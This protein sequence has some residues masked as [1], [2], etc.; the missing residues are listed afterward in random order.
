MSY[1]PARIPTDAPIRT[2][3][4]RVLAELARRRGVE[5]PCDLETPEGIYHATASA[6]VSRV[7]PSGLAD[8]ARAL[9]WKRGEAERSADPEFDRLTKELYQLYCFLVGGCGE[10]SAELHQEALTIAAE[11]ERREIAAALAEAPAEAPAQR[12]SGRL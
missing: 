12:R 1:L 8:S 7:P 9:E 2:T 5:I 6:W 10:R 11:F 4:P 3:D